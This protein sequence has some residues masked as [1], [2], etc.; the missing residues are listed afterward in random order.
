MVKSSPF[1]TEL[2]NTPRECIEA[3][4]K[5]YKIVECCYVFYEKYSFSDVCDSS[6]VTRVTPEEMLELA[7]EFFNKYGDVEFDGV[8]EDNAHFALGCWDESVQP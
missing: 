8:S 7:V 6:D 1:S 2:Y 4:F 5:K 3:Q